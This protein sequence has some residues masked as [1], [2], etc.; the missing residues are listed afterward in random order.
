M[1]I[2]TRG[3]YALRVIIDLAE[4]NS[5]AYIPLKEIAKRQDISQKYMETIMAELSKNG[6]VDGLHGKGGGYRLARDPHAYNLFEILTLTEGSLAPVT[7]LEHGQNKCGDCSGC[8]TLPMW[9]RL[10]KMIRDYFTGITLADIA[11]EGKLWKKKTET[12]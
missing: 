10:D 7:C 5:G 3:R 9:S 8:R 1:M 6:L 11:E 4:H 12:N 2:S